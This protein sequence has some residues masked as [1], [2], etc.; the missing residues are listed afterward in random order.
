MKEERVAEAELGGGGGGSVTARGDVE[1]GEERL[2]SSLLHPLS[3]RLVQAHCVKA[4]PSDL[5]DGMSGKGGEGGGR[6]LDEEHKR[7][8]REGRK[9]VE[10]RRMSRT[11]RGRQEEEEGAMKLDEKVA[12]GM[13]E[14]LTSASSFRCSVLASISHSEKTSTPPG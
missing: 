6:A 4:E 5:K 13:L 2:E 9:Y 7:Y 10:A 11:S 3:S 1:D 14:S 12:D 8:S